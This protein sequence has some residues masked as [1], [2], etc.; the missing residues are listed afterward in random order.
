MHRLVLVVSLFISAV[1]A[2]AANA[3]TS[4]PFAITLAQRSV[5]ALTGG[6]PVTDVTLNANVISIFGSDNETGTGTL[7]AKGTSESRVDL[8]LS[9]GT[10]SDV[11]NFTSDGGPGG[12]WEK[13][14]GTSTA[15][16]N[17]NCWTDAAW[18]FPALSS[19]TQ[20]ANPNFIFKYIGQQ[21]HAGL[22]TQHIRVFQIDQQNNG[23]LQRLSTTDFYLDAN[24]SL[25]LAVASQ[26]HADRDMNTDIATEVRFANYQA[27]S[28]FQV[29]FHLQR[30]FSGGV[31]LD[32]TVTSAVF[33]T[34]LPD[35]LFTLQ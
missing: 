21:Q 2:A 6:A 29:P 22:N 27:V 1:C 16:A 35:S 25:P 9:G 24:S 4:D 30:M 23:T 34:G 32:V 3:P 33:N 8:S 17:H 12:A 18:F 20:T 31:V 7:E 11:R 10:R 26:V 14:G 13:N 15:Y 19:L 5:A 28:G